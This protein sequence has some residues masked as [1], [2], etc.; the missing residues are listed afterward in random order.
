[1]SLEDLKAHLRVEETADDDLIIA[2]GKTARAKIERDTGRVLCTQELILYLDAFPTSDS[3]PIY[4]R[5]PPVVTVDKIEY[6]DENG[7]GATWEASL[8]Q[9]DVASSPARILPAYGCTYP[10]AREQLNA[11]SIELTCGYGDAHD[12]PE[13]LRHALKM[14]VATWYEHREEVITGTIVSSMPAPIAYQHLIAPFWV[15]SFR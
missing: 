12:V 13:E 15:P 14:L 7:T 9:T 6:V 10:S 4:V 8:Y 3:E 1:V 2:L 5:R 11:V